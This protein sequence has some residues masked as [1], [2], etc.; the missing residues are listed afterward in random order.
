MYLDQINFITIFVF[1]FIGYTYFVII[2][3][4]DKN[5]SI[6]IITIIIIIIINFVVTT[7]TQN[8]YELHYSKCLYLVT[9]IIN[10]ITS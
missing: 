2:A 10:A 7:T 1:N 9:N 3:I 4:T 8:L 6:V 5:S